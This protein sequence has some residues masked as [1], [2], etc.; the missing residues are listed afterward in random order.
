MHS[1]EELFKNESLEGA[2]ETLIQTE[3]MVN[4]G[5]GSQENQDDFATSSQESEHEDGEIIIVHLILLFI[6]LF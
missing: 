2:D 6:S 5:I 1:W 4:S 3:E